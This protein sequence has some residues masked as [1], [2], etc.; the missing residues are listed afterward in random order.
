MKYLL[1]QVVNPD[2]GEILGPNQDGEIC[3]KGPLVMKGEKFINRD[4]YTLID[5]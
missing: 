5:G 1:E 4:I 3:V 2:T